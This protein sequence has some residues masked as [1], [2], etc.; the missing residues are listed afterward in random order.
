VAARAP[1]RSPG[2]VAGGRHL[3]RI[4]VAGAV[5]VATLLVLEAIVRVGAAVDT[6]PAAYS[7]YLPFTLPPNMHQR[8]TDQAGD[9]YD[10]AT[11]A[12]G[13]RGTA[14][15]R[16]EPQP[17]V[18]RV[19]VLGDS[20]AFGLGVSGD[21]TFP[22]RLGGELHESAAP[23]DVVNAGYH[24]GYSPDAYYAYL[25]REGVQL[26]P[27]IVVVTLY[28]ANDIEDIADNVPGPTDEYTGPLAVR[29]T[30]LYTDY[31]GSLLIPGRV[32]WHV[33]APLSR[34]SR[35]SI[36]VNNEMALLS[37]PPADTR[38]RLQEPVPPEIAWQR[39]EAIATAMDVFCRRE[40]IA[41]FFVSLPRI[42]V[43]GVAADDD[44]DNDRVRAIVSGTLG[45]PY[46]DLRGIIVDSAH[47]IPGDGHFNRLGNIVAARA[48]SKF[49][50]P[51][52][53]E[54]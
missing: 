40:R 50:L 42:P 10:V 3:A 27:A 46:L 33:R 49:I 15:A 25:R 14:P 12:F 23:A 39:F 31:K 45:L 29:T 53:R 24:D 48:I 8:F 19:L 4:A 7:D 52:V 21:E 17:G 43:E 38:G 37:L 35:L 34:Y 54:R 32:P 51:A 16:I 9:S 20:F 28:A 44:A 36:V 2:R 47:R 30:R 6:S 1:E 11:N 41:L 5:I 26:R 22:A 18:V 13:Y